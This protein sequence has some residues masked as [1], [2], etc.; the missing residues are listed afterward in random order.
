MS[1]NMHGRLQSVWLQPHSARAPVAFHPHGIWHVWTLLARE[2]GDLWIG[3]RPYWVAWSVVGRGGAVAADARSREVRLRQSSCEA[4]EQSRAT[5]CG[6]GGAKAGDQGER[7]SAKHA[8]DTEPGA[9]DPGAGSRT[10]S[11]KAKE[12]RQ[13]FDVKHPREEPDA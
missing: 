7:G 11:R 3:H 10:A 9:R 1:Y 12:A 6:A 8:P 2:P 4:D 13:R 5:G